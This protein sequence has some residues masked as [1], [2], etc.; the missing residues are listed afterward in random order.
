MN[1]LWK[2]EREQVL[3][4]KLIYRGWWGPVGDL[5]L[6]PTCLLQRHVAGGLS[7]MGELWR[8]SQDT[9]SIL[10]MKAKY[11]YVL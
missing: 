6:R 2:W 5:S 4:T 7:D 8:T 10:S 3:F 9:R 11:M 1:E